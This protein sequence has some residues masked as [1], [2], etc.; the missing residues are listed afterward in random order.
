MR[1]SLLLFFIL[2]SSA[3]LFAQG[4]SEKEIVS[5]ISAFNTFDG[6]V[7]VYYDLEKHYKTNYALVKLSYSLD[8]G[9]TYTPI[10]D[11]DGDLGEMVAVGPN[12]KA[13]WIPS[14]S[15]YGLI[16]N[17]DIK[18]E[19]D[20]YY[21]GTTMFINYLHFGADYDNATE[22]LDTDNYYLAQKYMLGFGF[23]KGATKRKPYF[24]MY[25]SYFSKEFNPLIRD[26]LQVSDGITAGI[27]FISKRKFLSMWIGG[28]VID[29]FEIN[30]NNIY[31]LTKYENA[32]CLEI[33][34]MLRI[35]KP[36][37]FP[38]NYV[39]SEDMG[40]Y[41]SAGIGIMF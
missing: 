2:I 5:K 41:V 31:D 11:A 3:A 40:N 6:K 21:V 15:S 27:G 12:K 1:K 7:Y 18:V 37:T 10:L 32:P 20:P 30:N 16:G 8:E 22:K 13:V 36:F 24:L 4:D 19:A 34:M 14:K 39:Y 28:G 29:Y 38:I 23:R 33:G 17:V 9:A 35:I 26:G 25:G